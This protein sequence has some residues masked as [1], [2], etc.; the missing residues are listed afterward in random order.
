VV[1]SGLLFLTS[2]A[3]SLLSFQERY[4]FFPSVVSSA[5]LAYLLLRMPSRS[6]TVAGTLLLTVWVASLGVH[7]IGWIQ[8]GRASRALVAGL[9]EASRRD[10]V[11]EIVI[12]NQ[13]YRVAGAP[14]A[15]DLG[16]AVRL[17]GGRD[18]RIVAATALNLPSASADGIAGP[19]PRA[20]PFRLDVAMSRGTYSGV[21]LPLDRPPGTTRTE[22]FGTLTFPTRDRVI[23]E[24][25]PEEDGSRGAYAWRDGRL[26]KLF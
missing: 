15:G 9:A 10:G 6:R 12:A 23:V 17:S 22:E 16:A 11:G 25:R 21:F 18:V 24:I 7:W 5:V 20:A 26:E 8:A 19:L 13:P 1:A 3:P 4:F 14:L 2:L